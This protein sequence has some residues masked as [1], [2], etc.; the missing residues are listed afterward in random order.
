M[1]NQENQSQFEL[2]LKGFDKSDSDTLVKVKGILVADLELP[3]T[4][5][6]HIIDNAPFPIKRA[7]SEDALINYYNALKKAGA[8]VLLVR[9]YAAAGEEEDEEVEFDLEIDLPKESAKDSGINTF[10]LDL[11]DQES[12]LD[13]L[14]AMLTDE[15]EEEM[16]AAESSA[17]SE[18][19]DSSSFVLEL[20]PAEEGIALIDPDARN[21]DLDENG[22]WGLKTLSSALDKEKT[23]PAKQM[24]VEPEAVNQAFELGGDPSDL[25][26]NDSSDNIKLRQLKKTE[27]NLIPEKLAGSAPIVPPTEIAAAKSTAPE[28]Q[29][30]KTLAPPS[31]P[32]SFELDAPEK[33]PAPAAEVPEASPVTAPAAAS[34]APTIPAGPAEKA[35]VELSVD[36]EKPAP[37]SEAPSQNAPQKA[38]AK[39]VPQQP[40]EA[41]PAPE[42]NEIFSEEVE[43]SKPARTVT[44]E[45]LKRAKKKQETL[46]IVSVCLLAAAVLIAINWFVHFMQEEEAMTQAALRLASV[47]PDQL[48]RSVK[49]VEEVSAPEQLY[50]GTATSQ[51]GTTEASFTAKGSSIMAFSWSG[52]AAQPVPLTPEE[53]VQGVKHRPWLRK[54]EIDEAHFE[55]KED[56]LYV[57]KAVAKAYV[58]QGPL[59]NR[60]IADAE[61]ELE[62]FETDIKSPLLKVTINNSLVDT[63]VP[64][65][66]DVLIEEKELGYAFRFRSETKL[67]RV[68]PESEAP[69]SDESPNAAPL[70]E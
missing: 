65:L 11:D 7:D 17:G 10:E 15:S 37:Q 63:S 62:Y 30:S 48:E 57:G 3:A 56:N 53:I 51:F 9:P 68:E 28:Q 66:P 50:K 22:E 34:S 36:E 24:L 1:G 12:S 32:L 52:S 2:V 64:D 43:L 19:S 61:L 44:K 6:Q 58:E 54:L 49:K 18:T 70:A 21:N 33:P 16:P 5:A 38:E 45:E 55:L 41:S 8:E 26:L 39:P 69:P 67:E 27:E 20:L 31:A 14:N 42:Q 13:A 25:K 46:M 4:V 47:Q 29:K 59:R 40:A 60:Y 35:A 23:A